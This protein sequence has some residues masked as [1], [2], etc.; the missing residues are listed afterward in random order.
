VRCPTAFGSFPLRCRHSLQLCPVRPDNATDVAALYALCVRPERFDQEIVLPIVY[1]DGA[2]ITAGAAS[3]VDR[4]YAQG[5]HI[6]EGY[7]IDLV[8]IFAHA[9]EQRSWAK[10]PTL[11]ERE[12]KDRSE[13]YSPDDV[14]AVALLFLFAGT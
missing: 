10:V 4:A 3:D 9:S 2:R 13:A 8:G 11:A 5:S 7:R 1:V 6:P 14:S 12:P